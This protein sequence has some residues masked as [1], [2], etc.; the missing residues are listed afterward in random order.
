MKRKPIATQLSERLGGV[1][2]AVRNG[3]SWYWKC[4]DGREVR[5]YSESVLGYDG[6][7]DSEFVTVYLDQDGK[8]VGS[9][10]VIY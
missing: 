4:G 5:M 9:R 3:M 6:Y 2:V 8:R 7:S 10:G 1:W